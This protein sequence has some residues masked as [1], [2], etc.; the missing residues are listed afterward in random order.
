MFD[1]PN[2]GWTVQ[3]GASRSFPI[4]PSVRSV[5]IFLQTEGRNLEARIEVL[6]GP[7]S[8]RQVVELNEDFGYDRPFSGIID[9]PGYGC[10]IRIVNTGPMEYPFKASVVPLT[11]GVYDDGEP[12]V[13][14]GGMGFGS[15]DPYGRYGG[16]R[17]RGSVARTREPY[18]NQ[19]PGV[20]PPG[21]RWYDSY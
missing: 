20:V 21:R 9:T 19:S 4:D 15:E 8:V 1:R 7:D 16:S 17:P 2:A 5:Q 3:G 13:R 6:Q 18:R 12:S 10:T 14:V 11:H